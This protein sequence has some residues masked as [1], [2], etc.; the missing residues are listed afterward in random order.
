MNNTNAT[1]LEV[2]LPTPVRRRFDYLLPD[3]WQLS[4]ANLRGSRVLVPFGNSE[5]LAIIIK[6]KHQ[7]ELDIN[8]LK[9]C[10][11]ILDKQPL[12]DSNILKLAS[13]ASTYYHYSLGAICFKMLPTLY[14]TQLSAAV[15]QQKFWTVGLIKPD[16]ESLK[17]APKQRLCYDLIASSKA[18][19][20]PAELKSSGISSS[21]L[22]KLNQ[23]GFIQEEFREAQPQQIN[24][25]KKPAP[26]LTDEQVSAISQT[27]LDRF[28]IH[29]LDG[30]TGSGKTEVYLQLIQKVLA[31]GKQIL[32][33]V[34]E[35]GLTPQLVRRFQQRL[36]FPIGL[37]HSG[38][39]NQQRLENW[40]MTVKGQ[41]QI[42]I[43]TRSALFT[44]ME[45]LGLII[46]DEEQEYSFKQES[47]APRYHAREVALMRGKL[48][49]AVVIMSSATPILES[50][51][52][53][54]Q[55]PGSAKV[56]DLLT[57]DIRKLP[58][59]QGLSKPL[60]D[61]IARHLTAGNQVIIFLN[62]RGY[63]PV[64]M[65]HD[66]GWMANCKR[67]E[68][69]Y[70]LHQSPEHLLCHHCNGSRSVP[71]LCPD[72]QSENITAVGVGTE[73]VEGLLREKFPD[74]PLVRIDRDST[75]RKDSMKKYIEDINSGKYKILIGTQMLSKGHH[76]PD[77]SLVAIIDMDG[78]LFSADFRAAEKF[79][80][81]LTQVA[82]RAG[83]ARARP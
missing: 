14:R 13:W 30:I 7:S 64:L 67:C 20:S 74:F 15:K 12:L 29:L 32:V 50:Y 35:I 40:T 78:A 17:R 43:G 54:R 34:P 39:N 53:H 24:L 72:C 49:D 10:L 9:P 68:T 3:D 18:G 28:K 52:N 46:I 71:Q 36:Q 22:S 80:Q 58:I 44:P 76:F 8:K 47:P 60:I 33:L 73:R 79:G 11:Q 82:G 45:K 31:K 56:A 38:L 6:V 23:A 1:I 57:L 61:N 66:C 59:E 19:L 42:L 2:V 37:L 81:L 70:T 26:P 65:C 25:D 21:Q 41:Y 16:L 75:R 4:T 62:R 69:S 48:N 77:V 83:R 51:Y 27:Q 55:R 63:A 5:R